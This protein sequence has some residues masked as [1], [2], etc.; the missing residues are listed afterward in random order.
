MRK[1]AVIRAQYAACLTKNTKETSVG[2]FNIAVAYAGIASCLTEETVA[3][4]DA[5]SQEEIESR[6]QS[7]QDAKEKFELSQEILEA[8]Q[9]DVRSRQCQL[10]EKK[11]EVRKL[12]ASLANSAA[13][14]YYNYAIDVFAE[15]DTD[16]FAVK[17]MQRSLDEYKAAAAIYALS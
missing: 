2:N 8:L 10:E 4:P 7:F 15:D 14:I 3:K 6:Y 17:F 11:I 1:F 9:F 5:V 12:Q 13:A 16:A